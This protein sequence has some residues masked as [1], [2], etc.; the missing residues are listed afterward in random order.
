MNFRALILLLLCIAQTLPAWAGTLSQM[1]TDCCA[2]A[3]STHFKLPPSNT[4]ANTSALRDAQAAPSH[5]DCG[6]SNGNDSQPHP[7][8]SPTPDEPIRPPFP[9]ASWTDAATPPQPPSPARLTT[10]EESRRLTALNRTQPAELPLRVWLCAF[11][12]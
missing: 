11:L 10:S 5:C 8:T 9:D 3:A 7:E 12:L 1:P 6:C 2:A 4:S